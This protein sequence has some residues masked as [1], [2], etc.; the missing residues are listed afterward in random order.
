MRIL[1][2]IDSFRIGGGAQTQLAGLAVMLKENGH[3]VET[4]SYHQ[5]VPTLSF[6][7][8]LR[9]LGV[10]YVCPVA[11]SRIQ[12][13]KGVYREIQSYRPNVVISYI[14]GPIMISCLI[15]LIS[16]LRFNLIVSERSTTQR[17]T[18]KKWMKFQL[19]RIADW[20]VPNAYAQERYI[21]R[22]YPFLKRKLRTISNFVDT[23]LYAPITASRSSQ[24]VLNL[25]VVARVVPPKNVLGL[26]EALAILK[27]KGFD[28]R[29]HWYGRSSG[30][31]AECE[32]KVKQLQ[33]NSCFFFYE[34]VKNIA[35]VYK[36]PQYDVFCLP[37]FIEGC[38]N[39]LAEAMAC[40]LP[41]L[42]SDVC[43]NARYVEDGKNGYLFD[44]YSIESMVDAILKFFSLTKEERIRMGACGREKAVTV[45]SKEVFIK[46]YLDIL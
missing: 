32:R 6:E 28:F 37:S 19:C 9:E 12:K 24:G 45:F 39:T 43:D 15:R 38:P 23:E 25:L 30:Y 41:V 14:D 8:Y 3:E 33:L 42:C 44:P 2:I 20:V 34:A 46:Q 21:I 36:D 13:Y 1:C 18:F 17:T 4:L 29:V 40:G 22:H 35:D 5:V 26:L 7:P 31:Q 27:A 10:K 11:F 16:G